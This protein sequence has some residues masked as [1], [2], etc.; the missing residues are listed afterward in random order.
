VT[1]AQPALSIFINETELDYC[2]IFLTVVEKR[3]VDSFNQPNRNPV[4]TIGINRAN[5]NGENG[6]GDGARLDPPPPEAFLLNPKF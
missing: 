2:S 3:G 1:L 6:R 4:S 5:L